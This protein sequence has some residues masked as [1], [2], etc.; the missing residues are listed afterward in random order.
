VLFASV[1]K[2]AFVLKIVIPEPLSV[3]GVFVSCFL[4]IPAG[5]LRPAG[6][7]LEALNGL[8]LFDHLSFL[9]FLTIPPLRSFRV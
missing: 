6:F 1:A 7:V 8:I 2:S 3:T 9:G 4:G 5:G